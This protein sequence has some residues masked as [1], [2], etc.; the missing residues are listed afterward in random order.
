MVL[1]L[2]GSSFLGGLAALRLHKQIY[3]PGW[4]RAH[5]TRHTELFI[6]LIILKL[7]L[8]AANGRSYS[9]SAYERC[10]TGSR[11]VSC[12][13]C[14]LRRSPHECE[15]QIECDGIDYMVGT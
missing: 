7:C 3:P 6:S 12:H 2:A 8:C 5:D 9:E 4:A 11:R 13:A 1:C 15:E 10:G 14:Q